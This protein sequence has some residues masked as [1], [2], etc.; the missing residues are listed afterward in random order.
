MIISEW[1]DDMY[2]N[3]ARCRKE[4]RLIDELVT[5]YKQTE[6][7]NLLDLGCGTGAYI[8]YWMNKYSTVGL[9]NN[10]Q[11]LQ[12]AYRKFPQTMFVCG[13]MFDFSHLVNFD[14]AI[15]L[16]G[17]IGYAENIELVEHGI[18][19][20]SKCLNSGGDIYWC[21]GRLRKRLRRKYL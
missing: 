18:E 1:Y 11:M 20:V 14:I 12:Q 8:K 9:D 15:C 4:A 7:N 13:N 21:M 19:C 10:L 16:Y 2:V 17:S 5:K 6:G 3:E